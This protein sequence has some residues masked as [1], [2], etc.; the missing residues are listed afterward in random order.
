MRAKVVL[1]ARVRDEY[2]KYPFLPVEIKKGRPVTVGNTM[3]YYLRYSQGGKRVVQPVGANIEQAF[4]SYQNKEMA[5]ARSRS[6]L[7][8][9]APAEPTQGRVLIAD[10][11]TKYIADLEA[12]VKIGEKSKSRLVG[13]RKAIEDFRDNCGVEYI[14]EIT[15]RVLKLHK[16]WLFENLKKRTRGKQSNTVATRFR[17]L[18]VFFRK[19]GLRMA[20]AKDPMS[21]DKGLMDWSD[22]PRET[23]KEH[24]NKYSED[25]VNALLSA[26]DIDDADL[27]QTFLRTGCRD[28]EIVYLHWADVDFRR[29]QIKISDKPKYGWRPKDRESR[30]IPVEDGV[31]LKRLTARRQRQ[32]PGCD[33]VFP[34]TNGEPD[35]HLIR[36]LHKVAEKVRATG[37]EFEGDV[38]LHR[39]RR[40][41]A[42]MMISHCDL[43]TVSQLLGHSDIQTTARYLAPDQT[44]ARVGSRTAF[45]GIGD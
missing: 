3:G 36:R 28:G 27:I 23:K 19:N 26:A 6:G 33:L 29:E 1:L 15:G 9:I 41:Y 11:V 8:P 2:G 4:V 42:S 44:K 31:L 43:Q 37:F 45:K 32:M 14:N 12:S 10:A 16:T 21:D 24:I 22:I 38:T 5:F 7:L 17:F 39:F 13:Y 35:Q 18:S 20:K 34:N 30:T 40:T 25:E